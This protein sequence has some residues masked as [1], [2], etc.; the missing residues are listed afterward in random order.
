M[1]GHKYRRI[2][3]YQG[4]HLMPVAETCSWTL[5]F[6][7]HLWA[8]WVFNTQSANLWLIL[9]LCSYSFLANALSN[10]F[11]SMNKATTLKSS[12]T[13]THDFVLVQTS[14]AHKDFRIYNITLQDSDQSM[15]WFLCTFQGCHRQRSP[16]PERNPLHVQKANVQITRPRSDIQNIQI[17]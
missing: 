12:F 10:V 16:S 11:N 17:Q 9:Q 6:V 7:Q 13:L 15:L 5:D 3:V 4:G 1:T 2:S 8:L 14:T